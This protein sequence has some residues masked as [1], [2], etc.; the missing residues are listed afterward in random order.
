M[1]VIEEP[2]PVENKNR[3]LWIGLGAAALFCL[4]AGTIALF[5]F[6]R[7][8]VGFK[9]SVKNDPQ[10]ARTAAHAIAD[11][12]LPAGYQEQVSMDF[13]VYSMV[14]ITPFSSAADS[15]SGLDQP[16]IMLA[17][18]KSMANP[19]QTQDQIRRSADQQFGRRGLTMKVVEVKRMTIRG[20]ET[21]VTILEGTDSTGQTLRQLVTV[22]PGKDGTAMLMIMGAAE[23]WNQQKIDQFLKSI[24]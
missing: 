23:T 15:S 19:Q 1:T 20:Q 13:F 24:H 10:S 22:F 21:D 7:V 9:D 3:R 18:F 4:C 16:I 2:K 14:M 12:E 5:V 17:Q 8:G 11:Y 6:Y